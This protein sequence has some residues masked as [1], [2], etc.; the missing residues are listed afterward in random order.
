M[1]LAALNEHLARVGLAL[2]NLGSISAQSVAGALATGTHGTGVGFPILSSGLV[3]ARLMLADGSTVV[4]SEQQNAELLPALRVH[5]GALGVVTEVTLR[6]V[7]AFQ[8]VEVTEPLSFNDAVDDLDAIAASADHVKL[9]WL[10]HTDTVQVFRLSRTQDRPARGARLHRALQD[11]VIS[12]L[13]FEALLWVGQRAPALV[14][15]FNSLVARSWF[16]PQRRVDRSDLV[17][18]TVR[19]PVHNEAEYAVP[20]RHASSALAAMREVINQGG[21]RINFIVEVRFVAGDDAW[22]SPAHGRD[23]CYLGA[24]YRGRPGWR[25]YQQGVQDRLAEHEARP[26]WGKT[27]TLDTDTLAARYP[28]Y[29]DFARLRQELDPAG[30]FLN[31]MLR[32]LFP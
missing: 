13:G 22:L 8:L 27:F 10:P 24:Y 19:P 16:A 26:H 15:T 6:V 1:R 14:P 23:S 2:P 32:R 31:T 21:H 25:A 20:A 18:N 7:P 9:W 12:R 4:V 28:R 3:G 17:F 5:L 11:E 29:E 30:R